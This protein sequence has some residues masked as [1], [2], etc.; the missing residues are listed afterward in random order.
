MPSR[1]LVPPVVTLCLAMVLSG[2]NGTEPPPPAV[3]KVLVGGRLS[4]RKG[5]SLPATTIAVSAMT[6][7]DRASGA[8]VEVLADWRV[9]RRQPI[10]A[11][12]Y[13]NTALA[14]RITCFLDYLGE[15]LNGRDWAKY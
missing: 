2:C 1:K 3:T 5:V 11:V 13:R 6:E 8:L 4:S 15:C 10:N 7:Q 12:Y 9:D 14:A